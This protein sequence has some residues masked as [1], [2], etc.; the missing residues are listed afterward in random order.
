MRFFRLILHRL[1]RQGA[2]SLLMSQ[3]QEYA[4]FEIG[5]WTYGR[6]KVLAW[7][8]SRSLKIG[9]FCC[10]ADGTVIMLGGEHHTDWVSAYPFD[11]FLR[12]AS[13]VTTSEWSRGDVTIGNDVWIG[14]DV[15]IRSGVAIGDG[16]VIG[17][18]SVVTRDVAPYSISAGQPAKHVR[19]RFSSHTIQILQE[20]AWW[21]WP[22]GRIREAMPLLMSEDVNT[23]ID[24]YASR[25]N[26]TNRDAIDNG[27]L[28]RS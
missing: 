12:G 1:R 14:R 27:A 15:L 3:N 19:F 16:A 21:N 24:R 11:V 4:R 22:D 2:S 8:N 25:S 13:K 5:K 17:A 9:N 6:P 26:S 18:R 23:F 7:P 28:T 20:L 10:I